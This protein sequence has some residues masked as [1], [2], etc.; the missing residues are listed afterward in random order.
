M[1]AKAFEVQGLPVLPLEIPAAPKLLPITSPAEISWQGSVGATLYDVERAEKPGGPWAAVGKDVDDTWVRYRPLYADTQAKPGSS[2]Y[3]RVLAKNM[4]GVSQPSNVIGPVGSTERFLIDEMLNFSLMS[5]HEGKLSLETAN[6]RPY[7]E[8]P[9]RVKGTAGDFI[10]Y[11]TS[12]LLK[13]VKVLAL[14]EGAEK[15]FEFYVSSDNKTFDRVTPKVTRYPNEGN[16]YGYKLPIKYELA[17]LSGKDNVVKIVF[18]GDAQITGVE[19]RY[20]R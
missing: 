6:A 16:L 15:E 4:I 5:S 11:Q 12:E 10:V 1:R 2:Y 17:D 3:Y 7:R 13:S 14:M 9:H 19:L 18:T 20:G 8:D